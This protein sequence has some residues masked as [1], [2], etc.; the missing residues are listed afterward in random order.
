M[1]WCDF[2][3]GDIFLMSWYEICPLDGGHS[4]EM[5]NMPPIFKGNRI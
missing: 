2:E 3:F 1:E 5:T 4:E